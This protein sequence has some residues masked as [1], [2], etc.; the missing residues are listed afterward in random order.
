[1]PRQRVSLQYGRNVHFVNAD[2]DEIGGICQNGSLTWAEISEFMQITFELPI[3]EYAPFPCLE[4]GD[5]KDPINQH[6]AAINV[7][8][9]TNFI[10]PGFYV[11]LNPQG[12]CYTHPIYIHIYIS[13][14]T[15]FR[16]TYGHPYQSRESRATCCNPI[17]DRP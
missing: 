11:L 14:L 6:G 8:A 2:N 3:D 10:Q 1:M 7:H 13:S 17:S 9:N 15:S 12:K 5:P 4:D 16:L